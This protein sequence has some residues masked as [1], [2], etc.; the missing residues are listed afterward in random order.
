MPC[1]SGGILT[2]RHPEFNAG[3]PHYSKPASKLVSRSRIFSLPT[4]Q[5]SPVLTKSA[6][7]DKDFYAARALLTGM[8][9]GRRINARRE[10]Q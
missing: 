10:D 5:F 3:F 7:P 2:L 6:A 4:S 9:G 8:A 1:L